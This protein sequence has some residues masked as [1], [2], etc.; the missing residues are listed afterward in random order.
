MK[1]LKFTVLI[2]VLAVALGAATAQANLIS[3]GSFEAG[4]DP[5]SFTTLAA[6]S[7]AITDWTVGSGG[8]DYIGTYWQ[9]AEGVRSVDLS[10]NAPGFVSQAFATILNTTYTVSFYMAGNPDDGLPVKTMTVTYGLGVG[11]YVDFT[12]VQDGHTRAAMGW[13]YHEFTFLGTGLPTALQFA[14]TTG[15]PYGSALDNVSVNAVPVPPG[16]LLLGSGLLGLVGMG[17]RRTRKES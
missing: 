5:V 1:K 10:G 9:A 3:N 17:W 13:E 11:D 7:T 14:S 4:T 8:V 15:D 12:F 16:A 6:G 2:G